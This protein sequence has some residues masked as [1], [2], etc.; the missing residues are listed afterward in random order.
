VDVEDGVNK[1]MHASSIHHALMTP[2]KYLP[3]FIYQH[4]NI[5]SEKI[6]QNHC[7]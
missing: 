7:K 4:L 2:N 1:Y 6:K 5:Q 3:V